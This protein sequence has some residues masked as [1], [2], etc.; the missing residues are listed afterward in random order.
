M[1][2]SA[3]VPANLAASVPKVMPNISDIAKA[4]S[5]SSNVAGRRSAISADT[6]IC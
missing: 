6:G 3:H 5:V 2:V 4:V 1:A